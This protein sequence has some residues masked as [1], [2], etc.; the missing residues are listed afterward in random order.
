MKPQSLMTIAILLTLGVSGCDGGLENPP[1]VIVTF[2]HAAPSQGA[3]DFLREERTATNLSYKISDRAVFDSDVYDFHFEIRPAGAATERLV[4]FS[5]QLVAGTDYTIVA[6]EVGGQLQELILEAPSPDRD[7]TDVQVASLH[8]APT[9]GAVDIF[10]EAPG[11]DL[12]SAVPRGTISFGEDLA[13]G[14]IGPGDYELTL[15]A[16]ANPADVLLKSTSFSLAAGLSML[17]SIVD[18]ANEGIAP[19]AVVVSG[20]ASFSF[21]DRNL[22]SGI[23]VINAISDRSML[24]VGIDNEFSPPLFPAVAFGTVSAY[25]E[26]IAPGS[27]DLTASPAGNPSVLEVNFPFAIDAGR[28][29]TFFIANPPGATTT[30]FSVDDYRPITGEAKL[31]LYNAAQL[32]TS[33]D[34]FITPPA[35]D[36]NTIFPFSSLAPGGAASGIAITQGDFEVTVR[37][38]GTVN[39]LAGPTPITLNAG[40]FYGILITDSIGGATVDLTLLDDFP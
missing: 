33:V 31:N 29:G 28:L 10:I 18:G 7:A 19:L 8:V 32:F 1:D 6:T 37:E 13:P 23:R 17:F 9:L 24:D 22:L 35:F 11:A 39:V 34:I 16:V 4:S 14:P 5:H 40:G 38:G 30:I 20:D 12:L 36:L 21:V 2:V 15:T 25:D 3:I 26:S 27:H